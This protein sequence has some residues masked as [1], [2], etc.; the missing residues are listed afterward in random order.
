MSSRLSDLQRKILLLCLESRFLTCQD[1]LR[2][3]FGG[4]QYETAHAS[5]SRCLTRL[6]LRGLIEYWKN[7]TRYRTA[8]TLTPSGKALAH[9]IM[10][11]AAKKQIT[12]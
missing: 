6:W 11:E 9:T 1:I 7:L 8:I 5:L 10:A 12:G 2:Q 4:R 3:V